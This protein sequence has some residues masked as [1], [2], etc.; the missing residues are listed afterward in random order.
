VDGDSSAQDIKQQLL[1]TFIEMA[2]CAQG[3]VGTEFLEQVGKLLAMQQVRPNHP[4]VPTL[5]LRGSDAVVPWCSL[6]FWLRSVPSGFP[7]F[8][9]G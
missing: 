8:C 5:N 4:R 2:S 1:C 9:H 6:W 3:Q 7:S